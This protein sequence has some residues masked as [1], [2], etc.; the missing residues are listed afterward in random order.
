MSEYKSA[1][2]IG[3][4]G[5]LA[6]ITATLLTRE[7]PNMKITGVDSRPIKEPLKN[8]N[9]RYLQF[10]YSRSHFE[11]L[12]RDQSF[13]VV[14]HLARMS[15]S[16]TS[17][18]LSQRLETNITST[19]RIL[20]LSLKF[21]TKKIVVLSTFHVYGALSDNPVFI[22]EESPLKASIKYPELRDVVE[23]DQ[24]ASSWMWKNQNHIETVILRPCN[25]IGPQIRNTMT[26]YLSSPYAPV[27]SDFNPMFQFI[28]E[29][30]MSR[31]IVAAIKKLP[32]GIYNV[33]PDDVISLKE[34]RKVLQV[35]NIQLPSFVLEGGVRLLSNAFWSFPRYLIDYIK[36]ASIIDNSAFK[37]HAQPFEFRYRIKEALELL[38][39]D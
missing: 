8:S 18:N 32:V 19:N 5:G 16:D 14:L 23:M 21:G 13:D 26:Q 39:L 3:M 17:N 11:K 24:L 6:R 10:R 33:A 31:A 34:A 35:P 37:A 4:A 1:L 28:H 36:F 2:I 15:H 25:I 20:D 29:Y 27:C 30:D 38:K 12:F 9:I 22:S 7:F